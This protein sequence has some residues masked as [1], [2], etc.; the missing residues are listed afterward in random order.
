MLQSAAHSKTP[1]ASDILLRHALDALFTC[2]LRG[3]ENCKA[4]IC[5]ISCPAHKP[6]ALR[7]VQSPSPA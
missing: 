7:W 4:D 5:S 3:A 1:P 6:R 2:R